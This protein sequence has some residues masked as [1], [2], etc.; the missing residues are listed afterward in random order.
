[1]VA[2]LQFL[3]KKNPKRIIVAVPVA[4]PRAQ[5]AIS[6]WCDEFV[7]LETPT[8]FF[9]VGLWYEDF[10][11]VNDEEVRHLLESSADRPAH[12]TA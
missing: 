9:G 12:G 7:A 8:P 5:E 6:P 3:C 10:T 11:Q 1:M 4:P 2:A